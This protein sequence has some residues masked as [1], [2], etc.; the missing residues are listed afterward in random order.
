MTDR[1]DVVIVGSGFGASV[2]AYRLAAAGRDVCVLERG[3]AY[4][5][6]SFARTPAEMKRNFWDPSEGQHGL[7]D[8]W[9]FQGIDAVV[10]SG[11][12]GGS[13]IY[14]NV[15]L[16]KDEHWFVEED[17]VGPDGSYW[18]WPIGRADLDPYY[19]RAET[20][21]GAQRFPFEHPDYINTPKTN[22]LKDAANQLGLEWL[23]PP[24]AVTF[25]NPGREPDRGEPLVDESYGNLHGLRRTTCQMCGE[26]DIGCNFG[27]KNTLDHNYLSAAVHHGAEIR[28]RSDVRRI[29]PRSDGGWNVWYLE[30][31]ES[32]EGHRTPSR[33]MRQELV[34]CDRL[35]LGAGTLGS[36]FLLLSNRSV[37]PGIS[38]TLGHRFCGN[39]DL[40][41][42]MTKARNPDGS[43]KVIDADNGPVIT[44]AIRLPDAADSR[45]AND[46]SHA[47]HRGAYIEDA[48]YPAFANWLVEAAMSPTQVGRVVKFA[49]KRMWAQVRQGDTNFSGEVAGLLGGVD[50][51]ETSMPLLG[52][53]RDTADGLMS[54]R[55]GRLAIDW[56]TDSSKEFFGRLTATMRQIADVHGAEFA[57]NFLSRLSRVVTVHALGGAPMGRHPGEGTV[58]DKGRVFG[59]DG[60]YVVDGA[61]M[62]GPIGANPA[63]TIAAFAERAVEAMLEEE[64]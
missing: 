23:L 12:G 33:T 20:M 39:G 4:P 45:A 36:T 58:D 63:L 16:R 10:S 6:G 31:R 55:G 26:C 50:V 32:H 51:S 44:S 18:Q 37:L 54:M 46:S 22:A 34:V 17:R 14:A 42:F 28:T 21:L 15:L 43:K 25:A 64:S 53:G 40:L 2:A 27:A 38:P 5:P 41:S 11:L 9:S 57:E 13:L 7:F 59:F 8:L 1:R 60:L 52:M 61:V 56:S 24:L 62:P 47:T 19:D 3:K 49:V 48:G 35:V 29:E 30:H